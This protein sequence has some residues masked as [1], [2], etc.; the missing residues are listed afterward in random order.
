MALIS[1]INLTNHENFSINTIDKIANVCY[2][3]IKLEHKTNILTNKTK[4]NKNKKE[5][6]W[7]N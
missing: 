1:S 3:Q 6:K 5:N 2:T 7:K 4:T